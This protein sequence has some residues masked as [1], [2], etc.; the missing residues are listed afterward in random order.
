[1][2]HKYHYN[3]LVLP[4]VTTIIGDCQDKSGALTQWAANM[5][6][7]WIRLNC[8]PAS[9]KGFYVTP[10]ELH[11]AR[12]NFRN[13]SDEALKIGSA[14]HQAIEDWLKIGKEPINPKPQVLAGFV[15]FLEFFD[16]HEMQAIEVEQ[17]VHGKHWGGMLD[18]YGWFRPDKDSDR[19]KWVLDW[20]AS[21]GHYAESHG[22]QIAAYA[23]K[24][25]ECKTRCGV[26]RLDKETG[27]P[28]FKDYTKKYERYLTEFNLMVP[29]YML[30]HPRIAK[31]AGWKG[32]E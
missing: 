5:V 12:F 30:R 28:D 26:V 23:S 3:G 4:S 24:V 22:P 19:K 17:K 9:H 13:V 14:V 1:M 25:P 31:A 29:L 27:F 6:V 2:S 11:E 32:E 21:K 16:E 20:K 15:A 10:D 18:Y 7:E 8:N